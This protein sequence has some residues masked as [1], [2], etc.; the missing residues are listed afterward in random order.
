MKAATTLLELRGQEQF[1][2]EGG[3]LLYIQLRSEIVSTSLYFLVADMSPFLFKFLLHSFSL[4]YSIM[5]TSIQHLFKQLT[6]SKRAGF[7]I[8]GA[9]AVSQVQA[10]FAK[11]L[12]DWSIST[13]ISKAGMSRLLNLKR[14]TRELCRSKQILSPGK[15][16]RPTRG[17]V[18]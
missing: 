1:N 16:S 12:F 7:D 3:A 11:L 6:H 4:A 15:R 8:N 10:P 13:R 9:L 17:P 14:C 2:R 5:T 18:Q